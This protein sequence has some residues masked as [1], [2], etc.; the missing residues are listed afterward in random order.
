MVKCSSRG[1]IDIGLVFFG[2]AVGIVSVLT[3]SSLLFNLTSGN[4]SQTAAVSAIN[5]DEETKQEQVSDLCMQA[6]NTAATRGYGDLP[7]ENIFAA[8]ADFRDSC[9]AAILQY[10]RLP[11]D[12]SSYRCV[13]KSSRVSMITTGQIRYVTSPNPNQSPGSCTTIACSAGGSDNCFATKNMYGLD[14]ES[15]Q[16][17]FSNEDPDIAHFSV[18][19]TGVIETTD[20]D[21]DTI[22]EAFNNSQITEEYGDSFRDNITATLKTLTE[23]TDPNAPEE[24][25]SAMLEDVIKST[26]INSDVRESASMLIPDQMHPLTFDPSSNNPTQ[27]EATKINTASTFGTTPVPTT[28]INGVGNVETGGFWEGLLSRGTN[29]ANQF[30]N[31]FKAFMGWEDTESVP[32]MTAGIRS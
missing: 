7:T 32:T 9:V 30:G 20:L 27:I 4:A 21:R 1:F 11:H 8:D 3:Y 23:G 28:Q 2:G 10:A 14:R 31:S 5:N 16:S 6:K 17:G 12:P 19:R 15:L 13:G 26:D 24:V 18:Q 25:Q 29:W 22:Y